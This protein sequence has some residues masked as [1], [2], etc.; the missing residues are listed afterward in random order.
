MVAGAGFGPAGCLLSGV[1]ITFAN[2]IPEAQNCIL[3]SLSYDCF[4]DGLARA[5]TAYLGRIRPSR[6]DD[7]TGSFPAQLAPE[8]PAVSRE[9]FRTPLGVRKSARNE[10]AVCGP[11]L[12]G[13]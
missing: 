3:A 2:D 11:R 9:E 7:V 8:L 10:P 1:A 5:G 12:M 4:P 6:S 13:I